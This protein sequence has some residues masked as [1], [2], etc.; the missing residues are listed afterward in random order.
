MITLH[1]DFLRSSS[2][3]LDI[4]LMHQLNNMALILSLRKL[5]LRFGQGFGRRC[6]PMSMHFKD[7]Q[8]KHRLIVISN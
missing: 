2:F 8:V 3:G 6:N 5:F 1:D 7:N 4:N